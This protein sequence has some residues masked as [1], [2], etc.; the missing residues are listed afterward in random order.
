MNQEIKNTIDKLIE[1]KKTRDSAILGI[2][3]SQMS[4]ADVMGSDKKY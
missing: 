3:E 2:A 4:F 1:F